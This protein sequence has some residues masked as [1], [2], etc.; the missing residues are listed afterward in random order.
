M[1][2]AA[3]ASGGGS[4][5]IGRGFGDGGGR[6]CRRRHS[7]DGH[8]EV[9][10]WAA[11]QVLDRLVAEH[12]LVSAHPPHVTR[13][14]LQADCLIWASHLVSVAYFADAFESGW[15]LEGSLHT[16]PVHL[17]SA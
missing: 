13:P 16:Y 6:F 2:A 3:V 15:G 12:H 7:V 8:V 4:V 10:G 17:N 9:A 5:R 14:G 11:P 1:P